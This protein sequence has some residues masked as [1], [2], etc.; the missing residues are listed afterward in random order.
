MEEHGC[1]FE[2]PPPELIEG[3]LEYKVE[4][5]LAS[6]RVGHKKK[7]LQYLLWWK[8]YSQA[9]N[10]W[11]PA[12]QVHAP[13]QVEEF[14]NKNLLAIQ[15]T[16]SLPSHFQPNLSDTSQPHLPSHYLMQPLINYVTDQ[17]YTK[18]KDAG[19]IV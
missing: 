14:Y 1:N 15:T 8:G 6:R 5:V 16:F 17:E 13:K 7:V 9:H 12:N 3:E 19:A 2:Q 11:K 10:S 18:L 4:W